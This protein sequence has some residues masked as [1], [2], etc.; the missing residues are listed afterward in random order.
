MTYY[1]YMVLSES[2]DITMGDL[3]PCECHF[4][5]SKRNRIYFILKEGKLKRNPRQSINCSYRG[6]CY[7]T[8]YVTQLPG[9]CSVSIGAYTNKGSPCLEDI[10]DIDFSYVDCA[11]LHTI[12]F[13]IKDGILSQVAS[14]M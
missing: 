9:D 12:I 1:G 10:P 8:F 6:S 4:D 14:H 7:G 11:S 13:V 5:G 2:N 3:Y